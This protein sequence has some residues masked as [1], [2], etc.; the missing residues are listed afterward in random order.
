MNQKYIIYHM[1]DGAAGLIIPNMNCYLSLEEIAKKDVPDKRPYMI[2]TID[3]LPKDFTFFKSWII[4]GTNVVEDP[5]K[6]KQ[7]LEELIRIERDDRLILD[8]D[9]ILT[10]PLRWDSLTEDEKNKLKDYRS[11]LLDFTN[12][13]NF[14][15]LE[16]VSEFGITAIPWPVKPI[17]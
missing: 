9:P 8:V 6:K 7:I 16:Q 5:V 3:E 10:N 13:P 4:D 11:A 12:D 14:P 17:I 1:D 2:K 15:W